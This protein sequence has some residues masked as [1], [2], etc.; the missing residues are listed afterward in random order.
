MTITRTATPDNRWALS[1]EKEA[2]N[3]HY[4]QARIHLRT[5]FGTT[6]AK[7]QLRLTSDNK[8]VAIYLTDDFDA[9]LES[10]EYDGGKNNLTMFDTPEERNRFAYKQVL[11]GN[12]CMYVGRYGSMTAQFVLE[13][14]PSPTNNPEPS[15]YGVFTPCPSDQIR[16]DDGYISDEQLL[17][18]AESLLDEYTQFV[19][20]ESYQVNVDVF[21][22]NDHGN[23]LKC[24]HAAFKGFHGQD[25]ALAGLHAEASHYQPVPDYRPSQDMAS[26][27]PEP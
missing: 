14:S 1:I 24:E 20:G 25:R 13:G 5:T 22:R 17:K 4:K 2:I 16:L 19:N 27:Q 11:E 3:A 6:L 9:R 8:L 12:R 18:K 26:D 21:E 15:G 23:F 7:P 10:F